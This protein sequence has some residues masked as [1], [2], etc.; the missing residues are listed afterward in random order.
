MTGFN[1]GEDI[2]NEIDGPKGAPEPNKPT[3]MGIVEQE[4]NGV[5]APNNVPEI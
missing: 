3:K 4:Q 1:N 2:K 5:S